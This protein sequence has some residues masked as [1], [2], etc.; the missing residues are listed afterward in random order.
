MNKIKLATVFSGI[1]AIEHALDRLNLPYEIVFASDNGDIDIDINEEKLR[2]IL[3]LCQ[4]LMKN[5]ISMLCIVK[6]KRNFV[7]E[8]YLSNYD[9]DDNR[10]SKMLDLLMVLILGM[11]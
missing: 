4:L 6:V 9:I 3:K 7:R 5:N 10:F 8:T 11:K 1:G 2:I